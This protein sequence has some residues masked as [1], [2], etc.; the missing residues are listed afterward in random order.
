MVERQCLTDRETYQPGG[1]SR[2]GWTRWKYTPWHTTSCRRPTQAKATD[3]QAIRSRSLHAPSRA[4]TEYETHVG[5]RHEVVLVCVVM[6]VVSDASTA[7]H[8]DAERVRS[9]GKGH[10]LEE[11]PHPSEM[12]PKAAAA[13]V[14]YALSRAFLLKPLSC[15]ADLSATFL[16]ASNAGTSLTTWLISCLSAGSLGIANPDWVVSGSWSKDQR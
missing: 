6:Q 4:P 11:Y 16:S 14:K 3:T 5:H 1:R 7:R 12:R 10:E 13:I 15:L 9:E 8:D 2:H